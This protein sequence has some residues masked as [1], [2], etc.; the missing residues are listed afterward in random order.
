VSDALDSVTRDILHGAFTAIAEEMAVVQYRSSFSPI[1]RDIRDYSCVLFDKRARIV[2][3]SAAIPA[4]LGLMQFALEDA[5]REHGTLR[6]GDVVLG[7]HPY[8]GGTHTPDLQIFIPVYHDGFVVGYTGS[9]A[10]HI[11]I[12]GSKSG[13]STNN[14]TLFEEGLLLPSVLLWDAGVENRELLRLIAANVRDPRATTG[15][16]AA[17]VSACRRGAERLQELC[18]AHSPE[19][20]EQATERI[21]DLT[22]FRVA[23]EL[24]TW[25]STRVRVEEF[26]DYDA[27]DPDRP[28]PVVVEIAVDDDVLVVD[29]SDSADEVRG[30]INVP[31]SS[32]HTAAYYALLAFS[33]TPI[34]MNEGLTRHIRIIAREGSI[35]RPR[36]PRPV[37]GRHVTAQRLTQVICEALSEL[38]PD[39]AVAAS[40]VS[41][42]TFNFQTVHHGTQRLTLMADVLGGGGGARRGHPGDDAIDTYTSNCALLPAE[43]AEIEYPWRVLRTELLLDSGGSGRWPGG[44]GMRRDYELIGDEAEGPYYVEQ[45]KPEFGARGREGGGPGAPARVRLKR[46]GAWTDL[47]AKGYALL[48]RGDIISF[49][50]AGGGGYGEPEPP[51]STR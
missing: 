21:L 42:P 40:H 29:L 24:R 16:L 4:Q 47:P 14:I 27:L 18:A 7:N 10:H 33:S 45:S 3:H 9:I 51:V 11:N 43:V 5:L 44:L 23:A 36:F 34:T 28:I 35:F 38:L 6:E 1:I 8:R 2:S 22:S 39:R 46:D 31:W 41:F 32:T 25:P 17:Q 15:D 49:E 19:T 13:D 30:S 12:G 37:A 50:G 26:M 48:Q 20:V